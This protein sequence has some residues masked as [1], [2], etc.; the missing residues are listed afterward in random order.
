MTEEMEQTFEKLARRVIDQAEDVK[1]ELADFKE[2]LEIIA[3]A[4]EE[5]IDELR[6]ELGEE[7]EEEEEEE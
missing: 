2:G 3:Q 6:E 7:D 5:R 4:L 1:C